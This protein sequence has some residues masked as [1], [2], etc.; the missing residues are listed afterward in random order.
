[1]TR[2]IR[3]FAAVAVI[4][5]AVVVVQAAPALASETIGSCAFEKLTEA[6]HEF[7]SVDALIEVLE[8]EDHHEELVKFEDDLESCIEAPSPIIPEV[9][10]IIWG[11]SAFLVLLFFMVTK[12]FPAVR[13]AMD[14]R[15]DKIRDDLDAADQAKSEAVQIKSD[16]AAE[17]AGAKAE[18]AALIDEARSQADRLK[19]DLST[20]AESDIAEMR[21]RAAADIEAGRVQALAD[22][23]A[24]VSQI[25]V[26]A[27][28]RVVRANLDAEAQRSLVD[29]YIDEVASTNG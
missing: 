4:A 5:G 8:Q 3:Q 6:G 25:A 2:R 26:G 22:L 21:E 1:M 13:G 23:R 20:R 15:A 14:E 12:G 10:E 19:A 9:N 16:H 24:E 29:A 27:A 28:E 7:G 11:G 18:G 17:L